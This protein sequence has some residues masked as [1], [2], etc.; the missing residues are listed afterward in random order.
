MPQTATCATARKEP[1]DATPAQA[2]THARPRTVGRHCVAQPSTFPLAHR[3]DMCAPL[4]G[5]PD[6][7]TPPTRGA[8]HRLPAPMSLPRLPP[9][10]HAA[11]AHPVCRHGPR[12]HAVACTQG[13]PGKHG[14]LHIAAVRA[15]LRTHPSQSPAIRLRPVHMAWDRE[16]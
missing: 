13:W 15:R 2:S 9:L 5:G 12:A 3:P 10:T 14:F 4:R 16:A 7:L 8:R 1:P 6:Q 11:L